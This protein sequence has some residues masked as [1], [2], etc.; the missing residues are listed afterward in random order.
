MRP[1]IW[2]TH[3][4]TLEILRYNIV[5]TSICAEKTALHIW[6]NFSWYSN[7]NRQGLGNNL[8]ILFLIHF[9]CWLSLTSNVGN[10]FQKASPLSDIPSNFNFRHACTAFCM[11]CP[12]KLRV[13]I[14]VKCHTQTWNHK[15]VTFLSFPL[16][17]ALSY[18]Y[19]HWRVRLRRHLCLSFSSLSTQGQLGKGS[20]S[21]SLE[22][23]FLRLL[24]IFCIL[25]WWSFLIYQIWMS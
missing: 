5:F 1:Y 3:A 21:F 19:P 8:Y 12:L 25:L 11:R 15:G 16:S 17:I 23:Y 6:T 7:L 24:D 14:D 13:S 18:A 22:T 4:W 10:E 2:L 9:V 20:S